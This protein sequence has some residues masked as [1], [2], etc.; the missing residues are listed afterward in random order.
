MSKSLVKNIALFLNI[1]LRL[2]LVK[3]IRISKDEFL[4]NKALYKKM[5]FYIFGLYL[6]K[7]ASPLYY[8]LQYIHTYIV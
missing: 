5:L 8:N 4:E 7:I 2:S 3:C 6:Y 1:Y